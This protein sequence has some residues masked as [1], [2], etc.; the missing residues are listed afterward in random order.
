MKPQTATRTLMPEARSFTVN[1][2]VARLT[3]PPPRTLNE[4]HLGDL[5]DTV[6][7]AAH[8]ENLAQVNAARCQTREDY[9]RADRAEELREAA[10]DALLA[11]VRALAARQS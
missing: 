1:Q 8:E 3:A 11:F 10:V 9:R 7:R 2:V 5:V 4:E 6:I